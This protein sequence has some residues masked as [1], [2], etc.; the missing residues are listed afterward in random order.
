MNFIKTNF[1]NLKVL[2]SIVMLYQFA[3]GKI[4]KGKSFKNFL[5]VDKILKN[6]RFESGTH[7]KHWPS[8]F[9]ISPNQLLQKKNL[10]LT[11]FSFDRLYTL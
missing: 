7:L 2:S 4:K 5:F 10:D 8:L 11:F 1:R 9:F 6:L 3:G